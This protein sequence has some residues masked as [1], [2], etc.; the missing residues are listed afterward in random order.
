[1]SGGCPDHAS[2]S[3]A[4][5]QAFDL[6]G[7]NA[8]KATFASRLLLVPNIAAKALA[9][10]ARE[11]FAPTMSTFERLVNHRDISIYPSWSSNL[12]FPADY[13]QLIES[14]L[15]PFFANV[16]LN[17]RDLRSGS[18]H[19][20]FKNASSPMV[21]THYK[22]LDLLPQ[23]CGV[24]VAF[25]IYT[26]VS[27]LSM[28]L[29]MVFRSL[30]ALVAEH[31]SSFFDQR[32]KQAIFAAQVTAP[33]ARLDELEKISSKLTDA[34]MKECARLTLVIN[35]SPVRRLVGKNSTYAARLLIKTQ[36]PS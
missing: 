10:L 6:D 20:I 23:P 28:R 7:V 5:T 2:C 11:T 14:E 9:A 34:Q 25:L 26:S 15:K 31:G 16:A 27:Y 30:K 13:H 17:M 4:A 3:S 22:K 21:A 36:D 29:P 12:T 1:M 33:V 8:A 35:S 18:H 19:L 32:R 24:D